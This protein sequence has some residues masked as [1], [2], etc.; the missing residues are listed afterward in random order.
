[1]VLGGI[2]ILIGFGIAFIFVEPNPA[3]ELRLI[4]TWRGDGD[5]FFELAAD[6]FWYAIDGKR[7]GRWSVD[8]NELQ[9]EMILAPVRYPFHFEGRDILICNGKKLKRQSG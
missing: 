1:M 8:G 2:L 3:P 9:L 5:L 4:G 6:G 7:M